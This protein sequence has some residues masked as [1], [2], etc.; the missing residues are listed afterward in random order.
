MNKEERLEATV[1]QDLTY[2]NESW[3]ENDKVT[4]P[5]NSIIYICYSSYELGKN[6]D[7]IQFFWRA[8]GRYQPDSGG[9]RVGR[10]D[11]DRRGR[12]GTDYGGGTGPDRRRLPL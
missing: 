1:L 8:D 11:T 9:Q 4:I 12:R 6:G 10:S 5:A 3:K 7:S 2:K